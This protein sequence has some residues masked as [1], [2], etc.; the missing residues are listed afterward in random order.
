MYYRTKWINNIHWYSLLDCMFTLHARIF[1]HF[2]DDS[3][4]TILLFKKMYTLSFYCLYIIDMSLS[5]FYLCSWTW[6]A[7]SHLYFLLSHRIIIMHQFT[8]FLACENLLGIVPHSSGQ[9]WYCLDSEI[10]YPGD[11]VFFISSL[12]LN[13]R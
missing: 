12:K 5:I 13:K 8:K 11:D 1:T 7:F 6:S 4:M 3:Y 10:A 2:L 9:K